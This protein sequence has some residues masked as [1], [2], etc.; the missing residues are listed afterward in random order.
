[1]VIGVFVVQVQIVVGKDKISILE[2]K[3]FSLEDESESN[4]RDHWLWCRLQETPET[5]ITT[6]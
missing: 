1:V 3:N 5:V 2:K 6:A 4:L